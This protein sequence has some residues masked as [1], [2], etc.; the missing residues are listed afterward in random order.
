MGFL[1]YDLETFGRDPR[2]SRIAQF[3][4]IRTDEALVECDEPVSLFC[5][6][7]ND[8][9]PSPMA[10]LITGIS[11][12]RAEQEGLGEALFMARVHELMRVPGTC[13]VG[14]NSLRFDDEFIRFGLY[15]NFF[16]PYEREW[17]DG[18]SRWDLIDVLRLAH[19]LRPEGLVWP[20]REDGATRFRLEDLATSNGVREGEAHEAL[21]DVRALLGLAR[22]LRGAQPK[23]WDYVLPLRSKRHVLSLLDI[24][25]HSPVFHVS[26]RLPAARR[27][28]GL[29]APL[30][31]D[32]IIENRVVLYDLAV[33]PA[34][35]D[36]LTAD[37]LHDRLFTRREDL[38]D[39]LLRLPIKRIEAN[40]CPMLLPLGHLR[41]S[42]LDTLGLDRHLAERH[43]RALRE[44]PDF[45]AACTALLTAPHSGEAEDPDAALYAGFV[46]DADRRRFAQVRS[47]SARALPALAA[48]FSD[49]RY[50]EL[51]FRYQARNWPESL[52]PH[53]AE[54]WDDYRRRRFAP[55]SR[56]GELD[57]TSFFEELQAARSRDAEGRATALLDAVEAWGRARLSEVGLG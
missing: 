42:E 47:M 10:A 39:G 31:R 11:P 18:N 29:M 33:D 16:D 22:R 7:A 6:P 20:R 13:S 3:A 53:Q 51:L 15:R 14:Y 49:A 25:G 8:L 54:A 46:P 23:F 38:P 44:R 43:A 45:V 19:A 32:P 37:E 36:G 28:A 35:F 50:R 34:H 52:D 55:G 26:G 27:H 5:K 4:A 17:R 9:L 57:A 48:Q 12:Q 41:D 30:G 21:S 2:R 1:W 40:R 56:L 24:A